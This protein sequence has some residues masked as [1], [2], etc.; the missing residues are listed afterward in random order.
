MIAIVSSWNEEHKKGVQ[1]FCMNT[2]VIKH[3]NDGEDGKISLMQFLGIY[4]VR[5]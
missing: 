3:T 4:V 5:F 1:N 2:F